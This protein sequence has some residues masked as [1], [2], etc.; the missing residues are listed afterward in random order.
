MQVVKWIGLCTVLIFLS[1]CS[2][3][4]VA[5]SR[6]MRLTELRGTNSGP[7]G[8]IEVDTSQLPADMVLKRVEKKG[9]CGTSITELQI[10]PNRPIKV[11]IMPSTG[12][13]DRSFKTTQSSTD[14]RH[15][16]DDARYSAEEKK[17]MRVATEA[18]LD[19]KR[20]HP[21]FDQVF[22]Y[23]VSQS[24]KGW[25]VIIWHVNGFKDGKPQ[26]VPGGFTG[27][28]L[29]QSFKVLQVMPGA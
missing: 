5:G 23:D 27:V 6:E 1:G 10:F 8:P 18:V 28:Q 19:P 3:G 26:F 29:D 11:V 22:R 25:F 2:C 17:A 15:H 9:T 7:W 21:D 13:S 16:Y 4:D 20:P 24:E 12:A 14:E